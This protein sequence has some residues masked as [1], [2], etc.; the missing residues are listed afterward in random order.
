MQSYLDYPC[1]MPVADIS[2]WLQSLF[3]CEPRWILVLLFSSLSSSPLLP[4]PLFHKTLSNCNHYP[5][6]PADIG[7]RFNHSASWYQS[8]CLKWHCIDIGEAQRS[9]SMMAQEPQHANHIQTCHRKPGLPAPRSYM[10]LIL[11]SSLPSHTSCLCPLIQYTPAPTLFLTPASVPCLCG[12]PFPL[13][14]W[15]HS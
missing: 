14:F 10:C 1:P 5:T 12:I 4:L 9:D 3:P 13:P 7:D 6:L 11:V 8:D 2:N 15:H